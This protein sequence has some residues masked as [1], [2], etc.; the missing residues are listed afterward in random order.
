MQQSFQSL[1]LNRR[2]PMM[3]YIFIGILC[4]IFLADRLTALIFGGSLSSYGLLSL[5]GMKINEAISYAHQWW[6]I[7]TA[8]FLHIEIWHI[9]SNLLGIYIWGRYIELFYGRMRM[10]LIMVLSGIAGVA[11]SYAFSASASL[12]ASAMIFGLYGALLGIRKFDRNLFNATFGM[13]IIFFIALTVI[14]GFT[15]SLVD[16]FGHIGGLIGGY[17]LSRAIG[18]Y[19]EQMDTSARIIY[20][21]AFLFFVGICCYIGYAGW[22]F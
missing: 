8:N 1:H 6:R 5:Y 10:A 21:V 11:A 12:G 4:F 16:N 13:Q 20:S 22:P 18:L 3:A 15:M 17:L 7:L 14:Y 2:K 9:L 19:S